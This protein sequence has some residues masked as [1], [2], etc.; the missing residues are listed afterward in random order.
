MSG[1]SY[2]DAQYAEALKIVIAR[3]DVKMQESPDQK[4]AG[5]C[6]YLAAELEALNA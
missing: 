3:L 4:T 2:H 1:V 5:T 6:N